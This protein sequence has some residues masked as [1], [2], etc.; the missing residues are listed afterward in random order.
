MVQELV[1]YLY[2]GNGLVASPLPERL[3]RS[4]E[5]LTDLFDRVGLPMNVQNMVIVECQHYH[6]LDI[7]SEAAYEELLTGIGPLYLERLRCWVQCPECGVYLAVGYLMVHR[8]SQNR[9]GRW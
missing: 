4:F 2:A 5:V 7:L 1:A 8:Q 6:I 3:Q 9:V